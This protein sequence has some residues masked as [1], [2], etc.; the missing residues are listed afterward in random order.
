MMN[1]SISLNALFDF[2]QSLPLTADNKT[3]L[4]GKLIE[5]ARQE[6]Q[7]LPGQMTVDEAK[8]W[9]EA[10][11]KRLANGEYVTEEEMEDFYR[12]LQ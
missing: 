3:W 12:T 7:D 4:A 2:L 8:A 11:E 1:T 9:L 6:S 10:S 5:S